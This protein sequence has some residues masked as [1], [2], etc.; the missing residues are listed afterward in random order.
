MTDSAQNPAKPAATVVLLRDTSHAPELLLVERARSMGFAGGMWVF[1]GGKVDDGDLNIARNPKWSR[2]FDGLS[3]ADAAGRVASARETFE[4]AGVLLTHGP[5]LD[6]HTRIDWRRRLN[7]A[8]D[9]DES[10]RWAEILDATGHV[11]DAGALLPFSHWI[12]PLAHGV[13]KRFDTL[14]YLA[15]LPAGEE[16]T[17]DGRE[18]V[19]AHWSTAAAALARADAGEIGIIFPTRRNLERLAQYASVDALWTATA[20]R[21]LRLIMPAIVQ[22]DGAA[23][24]TIPDDADYPVTAEKIESAMR[25]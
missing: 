6:A 2:G 13:A 25:G 16:M 5:A 24:L 9:H 1:P 23:W 12:P 17:P 4:E 22:R 21:E 10:K 3:D 14:F 7:L 8:N 19:T 15:R 20:A 18:A 11:L